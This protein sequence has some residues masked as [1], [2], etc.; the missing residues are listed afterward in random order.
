MDPEVEDQLAQ[1]TIVVRPFGQHSGKVRPL[2]GYG[3]LQAKEEACKVRAL[4]SLMRV[5]VK[6]NFKVWWQLS[7]EASNFLIILIH[8][9]SVALCVPAVI[10]AAG[11]DGELPG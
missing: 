3:L 1:E 2:C 10:S 7:P 8:V 6:T 4:R 9:F 5:R 11:A